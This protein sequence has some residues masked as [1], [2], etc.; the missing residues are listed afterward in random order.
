[1]KDVDEDGYRYIADGVYCR[2]C[3]SLALQFQLK[4]MLS[5]LVAIPTSAQRHIPHLL[6]LDPATDYVLCDSSYNA[7]TCAYATVEL[8]WIKANTLYEQ[9]LPTAELL[10][11]HEEMLRDKFILNGHVESTGEIAH[12]HSLLLELHNADAED[13]ADVIDEEDAEVLLLYQ[14]WTLAIHNG[15]E[16][17]EDEDEEGGLNRRVSRGYDHRCPY[18]IEHSSHVFQTLM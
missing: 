16:N 5:P 1:V 11:A 15:T 2:H 9:F 10:Y 8:Y 4:R 13:T 18:R 17:E 14:K 12:R 7:G 6:K 3:R